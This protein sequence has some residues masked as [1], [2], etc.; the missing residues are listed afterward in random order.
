MQWYD[1]AGPEGAPPIVLIHDGAA[2]RHMWTAQLEGLAGDYRL[3][4][5]DLPGNGSLVGKRQD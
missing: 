1:V 3:V 5:P 2:N 4:A